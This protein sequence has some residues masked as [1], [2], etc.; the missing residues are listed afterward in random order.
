MIDGAA[1]LRELSAYDVMVPRTSAIILDGEKA[2]HENLRIIRSSGYSRF[3]FS[4]SGEADKIDGIVMAR[5]MLL[6]L[7]ERALGPRDELMQLPG[8][9]F[10]SPLARKADY[11]KIGRAH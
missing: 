6:A 11:V 3:P 4:K 2:I 8:A 10:L 5:D 1:R 7:H 9:E